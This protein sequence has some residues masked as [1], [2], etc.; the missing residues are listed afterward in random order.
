VFRS[1]HRPRIVTQSRIGVMS[2]RFH[3]CRAAPAR[4]RA[5]T[6]AAVRS[7]RCQATLR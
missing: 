2:P 1:S 7:A 4:A 6:G 5:A 3:T